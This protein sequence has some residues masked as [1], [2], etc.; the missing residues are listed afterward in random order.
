MPTILGTG[1]SDWPLVLA[2]R[3]VRY[4]SCQDYLTRLKDKDPLLEQGGSKSLLETHYGRIEKCSAELYQRIFTPFDAEFNFDEAS[5]RKMID[6]QINAGVDV[7]WFLGWPE[8]G[9]V[10]IMISERR[11]LK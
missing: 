4:D 2:Q 9:P 5:F 11:S 10:R 1:V 3:W 6:F 7:L 8:W